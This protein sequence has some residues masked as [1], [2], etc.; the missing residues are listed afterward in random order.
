MNRKLIVVAACLVF[1]TIM[2]FVL[3][4]EKGSKRQPVQTTEPLWK[5]VVTLPKTNSSAALTNAM[6]TK[7]Q[8]RFRPALRLLLNDSVETNRECDV[9]LL[10]SSRLHRNQKTAH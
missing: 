1:A 2:A 8:M 4:A 10:N 7:Q 9:S 6:P 3:S 5:L